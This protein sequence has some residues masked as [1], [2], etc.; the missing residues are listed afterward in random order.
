MWEITYSRDDER[1]PLGELEVEFASLRETVFGNRTFLWSLLPD[2]LMLLLVIVILARFVGQR[3]T[4]PLR[5]LNLDIDSIDLTEPVPGWWVG[6]ERQDANSETRRVRQVI[7]DAWERVQD[8]IRERRESEANLAAS[9]K[10]KSIL[11]QEIHHR[12]KNNLQMVVSLLSLQRRSIAN[13]EAQEALRDSENRV[14]SMSLVHELLYRADRYTDIDL[15]SYMQDLAGTI[16]YQ[17]QTGAC[18]IS[19]E[20][21]IETL[22]V[23]LGVAIPLGLIVNE[24]LI[25]AM[26]HAFAGRDTGAIS[27]STSRNQET[28]R[29]TVS[30]CDDG[31]GLPENWLE[32]RKGSLGLQIVDAL[33]SQIK[34]ELAVV[35]RPGNTCFAIALTLEETP[36]LEQI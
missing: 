28:G 3:L 4:E 27:I 12:V 24:L 34:A 8:Q 11:L 19:L 25:N 36:T 7:G 32:V 23:D 17:T 9:V 33:C 18:K 5:R 13:P 6:K 30:V 2:L 35:S 1:L 15:A 21:K 20:Y 29:T 16:V 22:Y 26:K 31:Q 14:T 10:E